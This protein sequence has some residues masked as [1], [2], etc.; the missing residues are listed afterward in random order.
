MK[1]SAPQIIEG[2]EAWYGRDLTADPRWRFELDDAEITEIDAA[3]KQ[4]RD[5]DL[6]WSDMRAASDFPLDRLAAKLDDV[7]AE[8]EEGCGIV[9]LKGIPA[10]RYDDAD[11]NRLWYGIALNLGTP[12][13]QNYRGELLRDI[14]DEQVDT[15]AKNDNR[16]FARD[17]SVFHSSRA[18]TASSG[19][20]RFH[21]DRC[22]VVGLFCVRQA[23]SG[24]LSQLASSV[25]I[26]NEIIR[27]RPELAELLWDVV[28]RS[29]HGE[30]KGGSNEIYGIPVFGQRDGKFTSHYSRTY[31][32]A[33]Q[34][35]DSVPQ[36]SPAQWEALDML[37]E[38]AQETC[39]EMMFEPGD[40]VAQGI[41]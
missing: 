20:L 34:E 30:E 21:T 10:G 23:S 31:V 32:E 4:V 22:D 2:P 12:I 33:A 19:P 27:R 18:R 41:V 37:A 16:L 14:I 8:L 5:R 17:G 3:L 24:G 40:K 1:D 6:G 13:Y 35:T 7:A 28:Y 15:D 38:I 29:R 25:T 26:S 9:N 11:I 36:M 39:M